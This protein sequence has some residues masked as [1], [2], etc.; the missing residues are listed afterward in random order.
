MLS[1]LLFVSVV[2]GFAFPSFFIAAIRSK[3]EENEAPK[4]TFLAC[5]SFGIIVMALLAVHL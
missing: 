4:K 5:V 2:A 3:D 1:I